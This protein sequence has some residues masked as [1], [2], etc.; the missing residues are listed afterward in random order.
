MFWQTLM[1]PILGLVQPILSPVP[2]Q[3]PA[4]PLFCSGLWI[5]IFPIAAIYKRWDLDRRLKSYKK[6]DKMIKSG[7][8]QQLASSR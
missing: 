4:F 1:I 8:Y 7:F 3:W 2:D 5:V 6:M